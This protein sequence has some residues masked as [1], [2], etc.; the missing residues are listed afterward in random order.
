[1]G[2]SI[3]FGKEID[4]GKS[5]FEYKNIC[6]YKELFLQSA[7]SLNLT[8]TNVISD[9][10]LEVGL[11]VLS[12]LYLTTFYHPIPFF[13]PFSSCYCGRYDFWDKIDYITLRS[14]VGNFAFSEKLMGEITSSEFW[15]VKTEMDVFPMAVRERLL[16]NREMDKEYNPAA[17]M[18]AMII[19]I[20]ELSNVDYGVLDRS[21][22]SFLRYVEHVDYVRPD[23]ELEYL[24]VIESRLETSI[25][26]CVNS[27]L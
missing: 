11:S 26:N 4:G 9:N 18:K 25:R 7:K 15:N 14:K 8:R 6:K 5:T 17:M 10:K 2:I 24:K 23:R 3:F 19:R 1:M 20:G 12:S 27:F 21:I 22:R 16:R 13:L